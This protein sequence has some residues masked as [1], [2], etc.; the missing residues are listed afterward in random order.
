M[1]YNQGMTNDDNVLRKIRALLNTAEHPNTPTAEAESA[2]DMATK[3]MAKHAIDQAML[4]DQRADRGKPVH[5]K[6]PVPAPHASIKS[7]LVGAAARHFGCQT[8]R[9]GGAKNLTCVVFGYE[10]DL[11]QVEMLYTSLLTQLT[12]AAVSCGHD[13]KDWW[14]YASWSGGRLSASEV[15]S[16]RK[17]FMTGWISKVDV[18]LKEMRDLAEAEATVEYGTS[19]SLVLVKDRQAVT[20]AKREMFPRLAGTRGHDVRNG[21]AWRNG[22]HSGASASIGQR[23]IGNARK[24]LAR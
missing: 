11:E 24:A 21:A 16:Y 18:R 9:T 1:I 10:A 20:D 15:S 6:I 12:A 5:L 23:G 4:G 2:L 7:S 19:M 8:V 14:K 13:D 22:Q 3:L 17:D